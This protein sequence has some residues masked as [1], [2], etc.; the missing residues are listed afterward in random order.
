MLVNKYLN[1][2]KNYNLKYLRY[3]SSRPEQKK[4]RNYLLNHKMHKCLL[5]DTIYPL[6][7]LE[8]A[9]IK[10]RKDSNYH[11]RNDLNIVK[12][13]CR[14]CHKLYDC[15]DIGVYHSLIYKNKIINDIQLLDS[16]DIDEY[17]LSE[18][19]FDYHFKNIYKK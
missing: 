16:I 5:C 10:P 7:V 15:G 6:Y 3:L 19:Y 11:E 14:N 1:Y 9:H 12:L 2:I 13:M 8:C 18:K 17:S 4:L